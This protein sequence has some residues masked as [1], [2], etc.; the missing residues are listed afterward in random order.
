MKILNNKQWITLQG[1]VGIDFEYSF[2][3]IVVVLQYI[4]DI[5]VYLWIE[6]EI[7]LLWI[8]KVSGVCFHLF[9]VLHGIGF[10]VLLGYQN[11]PS[12]FDCV[13]SQLVVYISNHTSILTKK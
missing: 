1:V 10:T 11:N 13:W 2:S 3:I 8:Q 5:D 9:I 7:V 12:V 4:V 6:R